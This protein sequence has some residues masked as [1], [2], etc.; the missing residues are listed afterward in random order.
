[1]FEN[2]NY[3]TIMQRMLEKIPDSMDK[4]EGSVIWDALSPA[5]LELEMAYIYLDYALLQGFA[6]TQDREYL[7]RRAAERGIAPDPAGRAILKGEIRPEGI[8]I[9]GKRFSLGKLNY[10]A[11]KPV[12][13][14]AG[15]WQLECESAGVSGNQ[16]FGSLIPI[17][18]IDGLQSAK[19]TTL[20]IPGEDEQSTESLRE[21]Y[22]SSFTSIDYGGNIAG[23]LKMALDIPGVGAAKVTPAWKGGGTIEITILD[24][25]YNVASDV[26]IQAV[27][28]VIDPKQ[29]G[30]G[31][32]LAF[33]DHVVTVDTA[34]AEAVD[35]STSI[36]FE[37]G[38]GWSTMQ[39]A[40]REAIDS[41]L[42]ELRKAWGN[43]DDIIV[44]VA[45]IES[46]ILALEGVL[47]IS[48]TTLNGTAGNLT[49]GKNRIP[50]LGTVTNYGA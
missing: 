4:R 5:A 39:E 28:A 18:Y 14:E 15:A 10:T 30:M 9:T 43:T 31:D 3:R 37:S 44:R 17:E 13:D 41:Y 45:Q 22:F 33:I 36:A 38:Y 40:V 25:D 35:V 42:S 11:V 26:L 23:Y 50:A 20:L 21:E 16:S 6:D 7:I 32:G 46:R 47:D 27:Q 49:L 8:D 48:G 2:Q 24:A 12:E 34:T 19:L 1:M 29:D